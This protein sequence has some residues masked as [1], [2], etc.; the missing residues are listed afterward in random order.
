MIKTRNIAK[1]LPSALGL[2]AGAVA[3]GY[4]K[5]LL[6]VGNDIIK[7][8]LPVVAGLVLSQQKGVMQSVGQGMIAGGLKDLA[9]SKGIGATD[10][11]FIG[12]VDLTD[13]IEV[14]APG[15]S[16]DNST[17]DY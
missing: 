3:S 7:S 14:P 15:E 6:P 2:G 11:F 10:T 5:K 4:V 13:T 8:L 16:Y 12:D 1:S 9:A 17:M